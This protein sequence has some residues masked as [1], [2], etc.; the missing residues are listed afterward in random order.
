MQGFSVEIGKKAGIQK[1]ACFLTKALLGS[2]IQSVEFA[3]ACHKL[4]KLPLL[5]DTPLFHDYTP[6]LLF[7]LLI[8][9]EHYSAPY[10]INAIFY[11]LV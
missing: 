3:F 2:G 8:Q 11:L 6:M 5:Y 9:F 4:V 10:I 1:T 7:Y